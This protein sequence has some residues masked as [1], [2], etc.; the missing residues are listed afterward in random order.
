MIS[1]YGTKVITAQ[2][3]DNI[4]D[5]SKKLET[6][7]DIESLKNYYEGRIAQASH[8]LRLIEILKD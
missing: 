2:L 5:Y 4:T 1:E 7:K 6:Y 8:I 3:N